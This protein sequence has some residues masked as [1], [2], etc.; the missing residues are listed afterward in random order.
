MKRAKPPKFAD[1][2]DRILK[3]LQERRELNISVGGPTL[4]EKAVEL[5]QKLGHKEFR[6]SNGWLQKFKKR[7]NIAF[8]KKCGE[9]VSV[10]R[11]EDLT[12]ITEGYELQTFLNLDESI[13][14]GTGW[15]NEGK[16]SDV[17]HWV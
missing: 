15:P 16:V 14:L 5:A 4:C 1:L 6:A 12:G 3:W 11:L 17:S 7:N 2:D 8:R 13:I 9:S 10:N